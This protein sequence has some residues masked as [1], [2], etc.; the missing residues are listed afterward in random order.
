M[1]NTLQGFGGGTKKTGVPYQN[2][3][4]EPLHT[5]PSTVINICLLLASWQIVKPDGL[6]K[7]VFFCLVLATVLAYSRTNTYFLNLHNACPHLCSV[8]HWLWPFNNQS[9]EKHG[10]GYLT[11]R[12]APRHTC[13]CLSRNSAHNG[14][15]F[16]KCT[17][18][19]TPPP[20]HTHTDTHLH[21]LSFSFYFCR[22][23]Y[24]FFS[25]PPYTPTYFLQ[26][27]GGQNQPAWH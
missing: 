25:P 10:G 20:P 17:R 27:H 2:S 22:S 16:C 4:G 1:P 15:Y 11:E 7:S 5:Q 21:C 12:P 23:P 3:L 19:I 8:M 13:S 6:K 24:L 9:M 26:H 18:V 14:I